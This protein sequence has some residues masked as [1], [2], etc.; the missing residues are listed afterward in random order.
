MKRGRLGFTL[1]ELL[2]VI[3][4]IAVLIAILIPVVG[5]VRLAAQTAN[6]TN[7][8]H[9]I[10]AAIQHYFNDFLAYPGALPNSAFA[11]SPGAGAY[12][13]SGSALT[14]AA[15]Y[16][17]TEDAVMALLGGHQPFKQGSFVVLDWKPDQ[18]GLGP[19]SFNPL[20]LGT[21]PAAA[22]P[23]KQPY[24]DRRPEN[25]TPLVGNT[26]VQLKAVTELGMTY[27]NDSEAPEFMDLYSNPRPIIYI[28]SE[29]AGTTTHF[30]SGTPVVI[31][32]SAGTYGGDPSPK[33][34]STYSYDFATLLPYL[35][36]SVS[37]LPDM[38]KD[39]YNL[40]DI[41][42]PTPAQ[43]PVAQNK[44]VQGYFGST[45]GNTAKNA[46]SFMLIDAGPDRQ[47]GTPDDIIVGAGGG[48]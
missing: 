6:T 48:Q 21:T 4:I 38:K 20:Q 30:V 9:G 28:R 10:S 18:I 8:M 22:L 26:P 13:K 32:D 46:G 34:D 25:F 43:K 7:Q 3:G 33:W 12:F 39:F 36:L 15:N 42:L 5:K 31:H 2:V 19:M 27:V 35:N 44:Y 17:Q 1:I 16:T 45:S 29:A 23:R 24:M 37:S 40:L 11:A 14:N 47:F 41:T